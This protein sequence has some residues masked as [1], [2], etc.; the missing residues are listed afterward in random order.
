VALLLIAVGL[1][2]MSYVLY[3]VMG[4][5]G[6]YTPVSYEDDIVIVMDTHTGHVWSI[7]YDLNET[8]HPKTLNSITGKIQ[9]FAKRLTARLDE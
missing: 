1:W 6:R 9:P 7:N 4:R 8:T 5:H 3:D 2:V